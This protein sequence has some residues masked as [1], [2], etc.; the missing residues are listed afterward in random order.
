MTVRL[1][2]IAWVGL[3]LVFGATASG[4]ATHWVAPDGRDDA[5][6]ATRAEAWRTIGR[7]NAFVRPG[8]VVRIANGTYDEFPD[9]AGAPPGGGR[10]TFVGNVADPGAVKI[11]AGGTLARDRVTLKGVSL[12]G[13]IVITGDR[14]SLADARVGGRHPRLVGADDAMLVRLVVEAE[15]FWI[16]GATSDTLVKAM[17]DTIRDCTFRLRPTGRDGPA[18]RLQC[19]SDGVFERVRWDLTT[20]AGTMGASP[21]KLFWTRR[22]RFVDCRWNIV[23]ECVGECD[24][25]GWFMQ[26]DFTQS[27]VWVRDTIEMGGPGPVQFFG[28]GSG[29]YPGS[30]MNNTYDRLVLKLWGTSAHG[31]AMVYQDAA[32]WDTLTHCTLVG[33]ASG[34]LMNGSNAGPTLIEHCTIV[35]FEPTLGAFGSD[36]NRATRWTGVIESRN[37]VFYVP[38][39]AP[40]RKESAAVYLPYEA[41]A[42]HYVA[43][44][45][46]VFTPLGRTKSL[47]LTSSGGSG[48]GVGQPWCR[49]MLADSATVWGS[50]RF[51]DSSSVR[52]FDARLM[53][54]SRA[55]DAVRPGLDAGAVQMRRL[56]RTARR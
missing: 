9:A 3:A 47:W 39:S 2:A 51:A 17:R 12:L 10:I 50:P 15:R 29:T 30:V 13:G 7:A 35:G 21:T 45:N 19:V 36:A 16:V 27:N 34:L 44:R 14:D 43:N 8:D 40:K 4:A 33:S 38:P 53:R 32:R 49:Q 26:R 41:A 6:G 11:R 25:A 24:E 54:G 46:V 23:N 56:P 1:V 28:S 55:L 20:P 31:A 18:V 48:P 5:S 22:C 42:G 52:R 37:N